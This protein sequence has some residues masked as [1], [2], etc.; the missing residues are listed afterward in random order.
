MKHTRL[1]DHMKSKYGDIMQKHV[2]AS[3]S[4]W[5]AM[6]REIA[7]DQRGCS[8]FDC[9]MVEQILRLLDLE[10][11]LTYKIEITPEN[12]DFFLKGF[13][14]IYSSLCTTSSTTS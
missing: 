13:R 4:T 10:H 2:S 12:I 3:K 6:L 9:D 5:A 11:V 1:S 14:K 7:D 8:F